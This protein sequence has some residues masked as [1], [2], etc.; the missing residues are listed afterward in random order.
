MNKVYILVKRILASPSKVHSAYLDKKLAIIK[1]RELQS[2]EDPKDFWA[3][4]SW[5]ID[6]CEL[7]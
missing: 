6:E 5:Y 1:I 4:R 3:S 7:I 2:Q